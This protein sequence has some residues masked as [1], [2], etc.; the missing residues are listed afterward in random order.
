M[1]KKTLALIG[2]L[3]IITAILIYMAVSPNKGITP[4]SIISRPS[5]AAVASSMLTLSPNPLVLSSQS[6][7]VNVDLNSGTNR[8]TGVQLELQYDPKVLT[9]IEVT[10]GTFFDNPVV[11]SKNIDPVKGLISYMIAI[12]PINGTPKKGA[13][14]VATITFQAQGNPG[15]TSEIKFREKTAVSAFTDTGAAI[16]SSVLK[17]DKGTIIQFTFPEEVVNTP[18]PTQP[19]TQVQQ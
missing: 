18:I 12:Q 13:G 10:P 9:N 5:P 4:T 14:T 8:V 7:S 15:Q 17:T 16:P 3:F 6:G 1:S 2:G 19:P 11:L